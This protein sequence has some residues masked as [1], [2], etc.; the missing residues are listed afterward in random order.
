MQRI[1]GI[2]EAKD[3]IDHISDPD[4]ERAS[5]HLTLDHSSSIISSMLNEKIRNAYDT[6]NEGALDRSYQL[7]L[8]SLVPK[9]HRATTMFES[10]NHSE[11][12]RLVWG[13]VA[14]LTHFAGILLGALPL[15]VFRKLD[16]FERVKVLGVTQQEVLLVHWLC[17]LSYAILQNLLIQ[18]CVLY[19][20]S[21][22][23]SV[24]HIFVG[25][26]LIMCQTAAGFS[27]GIFLCMVSRSGVLIIMVAMVTEAIVSCLC[28]MHYKSHFFLYQPFDRIFFFL[29]RF[30]LALIGNVASV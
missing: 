28:G 20:T 21:A 26:A 12:D 15:T 17:R 24:F 1:D 4:Q 23:F 14:V 6:F 8:K 2:L 29:F 13:F 25:V 30:F 11:A 22:N 10:D 19:L 7:D 5:F 9:L 16:I 18:I 3:N 27:F